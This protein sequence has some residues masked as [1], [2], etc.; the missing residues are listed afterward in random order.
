MGYSFVVVV[1]MSGGV[2]SSVTARLLANEVSEPQ[3]RVNYLKSWRI[4]TFLLYLCEIGTREMKPGPITAVSGNK[5]GK[6]FSVFAS[7][8]PSLAKW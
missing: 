3:K 2:D 4:M 8:L 6:T 7:L 1:A 5:T